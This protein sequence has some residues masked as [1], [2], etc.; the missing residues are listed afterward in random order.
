MAKNIYH[1]I[2]DLTPQQYRKALLRLINLLTPEQYKEA[3]L[4]LEDQHPIT[5]SQWDM[6]RIQCG[7]PDHTLTANQLARKAHLKGKYRAVNLL[8]GRLAHRLWDVFALP[9]PPEKWELPPGFPRWI[10]VLEPEWSEG[11]S[12]ELKGTMHRSLVKALKRLPGRLL[13]FPGALFGEAE[14]NALVELAAVNAVTN[15]YRSRGW[16]VQPKE[17]E[18]VGYDLLC[19]HGSAVHHVE[20]KGIRG[21]VCSFIITANEK[22]KA[23]LDPAFRLIAVTHA[24][25]ANRRRLS[26]FMGPEVLRKFHFAPLSFMAKLR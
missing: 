11:T 26:K 9:P 17:G 3:L 13:L 18:S 1:L 24:L 4:R 12:G 15:D 16:R 25:E 19:R 22:K 5:H 20:V 8:Y 23:E 2:D 10:W 21:A 7:E 6:L 14:Q